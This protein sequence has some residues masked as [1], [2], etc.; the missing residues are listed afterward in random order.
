[1]SDDAD[2]HDM[3]LALHTILLSS[4]SNERPRS[5]WWRRILERV[6][7]ARVRLSPA[8]SFSLY[9]SHV[10]Q[11]MCRRSGLNSVARGDRDE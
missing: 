11:H 9:R 2:A 4:A 3:H 5:P 1:V 8:E 6:G 10:E 7:L